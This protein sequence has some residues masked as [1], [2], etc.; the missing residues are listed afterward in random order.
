MFH[1]YETH[2]YSFQVFSIYQNVRQSRSSLFLHLIFYSSVYVLVCTILSV[3]CFL[4]VCVMCTL[5]RKF[6]A[7]GYNFAGLNMFLD[8]I[9]Y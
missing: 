5:L 1:I 2:F 8:C 6:D 4:N 9:C 7:M 3:F